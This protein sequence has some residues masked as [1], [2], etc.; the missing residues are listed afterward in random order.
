MRAD[1]YEFTM[2]N[3]FFEHGYK[4]KT[5]YFDMFFRKVPDG[6][7]YAIMMGV[8]QMLKYLNDLHFTDEDIEYLRGRKIFSEGFLKYLKEFKFEC[9]VWA[10]KEGTPIVAGFAHTS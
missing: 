5:V 8:E 9:D 4:D 10:I 6:G 7:G 1:F 2:A 3:G